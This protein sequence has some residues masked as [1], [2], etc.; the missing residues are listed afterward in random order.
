MVASGNGCVDMNVL[1]AFLGLLIV[2]ATFTPARAETPVETRLIVDNAP[3]GT[4]LLASSGFVCPPPYHWV[5]GKHF[6]VTC[7]SV[8]GW[9][10]TVRDGGRGKD[11]CKQ[12]FTISGYQATDYSGGHCS[13][14]HNDNRFTFSMHLK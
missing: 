5:T 11:Y 9:V 10:A 4:M 12:S 2:L 8:R 3:G 6:E 7:T 14:S 13:M 1:R